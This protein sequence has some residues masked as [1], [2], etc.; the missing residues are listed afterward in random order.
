MQQ[1]T[2]KE[3]AEQTHKSKQ[4]IYTLA[5]KLG[6]KPTIEE[7]NNVKRGRKEKYGN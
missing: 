3:I 1:M 4:A 7:V 5:K 2:I 6:R